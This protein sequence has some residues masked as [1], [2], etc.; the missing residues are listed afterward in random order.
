MYST[1]INALYADGSSTIILKNI[2]IE[3]A[4]SGEKG[5]IYLELPC[6]ISLINIK[7]KNITCAKGGGVFLIKTGINLVMD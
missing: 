3:N 1:S 2:T 4:Y 7:I 6:N 5:L